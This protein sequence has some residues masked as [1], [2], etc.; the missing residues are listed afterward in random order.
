MSAPAGPSNPSLVT[1]RIRDSDTVANAQG[2]R[3]AEED[4]EGEGEVVNKN[5]RY[6]KDKREFPLFFLVSSSIRLPLIRNISSHVA[7]RAQRGTRTTSTT[8]RS[9]PLPRKTINP[10]HSPRNLALP[11]FSRNTVNSTSGRVGAR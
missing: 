1:G 2:K 8:G 6:R 3:K 10:V 4:A 9:T 5:K 11:S 7:F